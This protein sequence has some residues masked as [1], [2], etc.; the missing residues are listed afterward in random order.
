MTGFFFCQEIE[1]NRIRAETAFYIGDEKSIKFLCKRNKNKWSIAG[2][3][4]I[5]NN[6]YIPHLKWGPR[7][8]RSV[9]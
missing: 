2:L 9:T 4:V 7:Q 8:S 6:I 5:M 3:S 1:R